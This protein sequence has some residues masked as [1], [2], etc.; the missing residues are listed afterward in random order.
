[1]QYK[2][3]LRNSLR[4][5]SRIRLMFRWKFYHLIFNG[6]RINSVHLV[7]FLSTMFLSNLQY[8]LCKIFIAIY[9]NRLSMFRFHKSEVLYFA[10]NNIYI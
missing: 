5:C 4:C 8:F 3:E 1:M 9:S 2:L 10:E 6:I 7:K